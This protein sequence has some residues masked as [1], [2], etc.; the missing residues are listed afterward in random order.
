MYTFKL[1]SVR[2]YRQAVEDKKHSEFTV[3]KKKLE[4][5]EGLLA[6]IREEKNTLVAGIKEMQQSYFNA[7]DL[8]LYLS[9]HEICSVREKSQLLAVQHATEEVE[10]RRQALVEAVQ[11]RKA[12]DKLNEKQFR[13]YRETQAGN[14]RR[15]A[16][17]TAVM[18]FIRNKA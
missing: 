9:F 3:G 4:E 17:E 8:S 11:E 18:R 7:A 13:E 5:E 10:S 1:Q 16:D 2:N 12:L 15:S 6:D 14:E